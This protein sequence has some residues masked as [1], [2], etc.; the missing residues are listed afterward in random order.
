LADWIREIPTHERSVFEPASG[1][2]AFL[3]SAMRLLTETLPAGKEVPSHRG[4][5]LRS[6]LHG[7]DLDPFA[8]ELARLSLTLTD[9]PN[10]DHWDLKVHDMFIDD[11]LAEQ[12]RR[13]TILLANPPFH[14][15]T[16]K[17]QRY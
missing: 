3:V 12:A 13:N 14:N 17:E 1:H 5:Y 15:F 8:L 11:H 16:P 6:R 10:P 7:S 9:I 4:P 2:A